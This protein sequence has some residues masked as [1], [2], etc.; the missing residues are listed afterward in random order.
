MKAK[1]FIGLAVAIVAI[2]TATVFAVNHFSPKSQMSDLAL[3]NLEALTNGEDAADGEFACV[4]R[5]DS[6]KFTINSYMQLEI[7]RRI[8]SLGG[9]S[10]GA[11][12]DLFGGTQIY[13]LAEWYHIFDEKVRC[14]QD[15]TCN[16][17]LHQLG[18]I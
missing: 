14:G 4:L 2:A 5:K 16:S 8:P 1:L 7:I 17:Y 6:C 13:A 10:I 12:V 3:A 15:I 11:D 9:V 18:L